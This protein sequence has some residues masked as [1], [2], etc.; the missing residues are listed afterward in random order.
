MYT[1]HLHRDAQKAL[2]KTQKRIQKKAFVCLQ[3][4][5][6]KGPYGLPYPLK[7]LEGPYKKFRYLEAKIDKDYRIIFRVEE[8]LIFVRYAGT[9]NALGTG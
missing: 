1:L 5:R 9:H 8:N 6:Q 3:H 2:Q 7:M 4:L